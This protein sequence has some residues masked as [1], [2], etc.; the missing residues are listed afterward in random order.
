MTVA[1][2]PTRCAEDV[3]IRNERRDDQ[4]VDRQARRAGHERRDE[5]G[6]DSLALV[7]DGARGHDRRHSAGVGGEQ[8]D[9]RLAVEADGAHDAVGDERGAGEVARVLEHA[10]EEEEQK[11]L[12][13]EDEHGL[14][15]VPQAVA[16]KRA[17]P[18]VR[19]QLRD[20][21]A[22]AREQHCP[23]RPRAAGRCVK[24]TWKTAKTTTRKMSG[25]QM[26]CSRTESRRRVQSGDS[27]CSKLLRVLTCVAQL[28]H[29]AGL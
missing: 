24:T 21:S 13:Q 29:E 11:N 14:H 26:R 4:R 16:Q 7:L 20:V 28:R 23:C 10:D 2:R 18:V 8:R 9:E 3:A 27:G 6:G 19:K 25:P 5:N 15:A 22:G 17:E 1:R 12:R